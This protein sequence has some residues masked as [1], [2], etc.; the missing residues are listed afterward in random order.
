VDV[1]VLISQLLSLRLTATKV[2]YLMLLEACKQGSVSEAAKRV[3]ISRQTAY[4]WLKDPPDGS[5]PQ[6]LG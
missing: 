3:G 6:Y 5:P 1:S 4:N 2:S